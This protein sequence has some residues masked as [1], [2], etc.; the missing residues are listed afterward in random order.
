LVISVSLGIHEAIAH[1][2]KLRG[3]SRAFWRFFYPMLPQ[4]FHHQLRALDGEQF[5]AAIKPRGA[6]LIESRPMSSP[7]SPH[8]AAVLKS[9]RV[10]L[11]G[12]RA[13]GLR[14]SGARKW[15]IPGHRSPNDAEGVLQDVHWSLGGLR[16]FQPT[17]LI[18]TPFIL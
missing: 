3:R 1:V 5:Y 6:S 4:T 2:G 7:Q 14:G 12:G 16:L 10:L 11:K 17:R 13:G 8:H 18:S 15:G 9:S